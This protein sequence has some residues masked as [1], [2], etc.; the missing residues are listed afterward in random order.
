MH[1]QRC[2][3][4]WWWID[5]CICTASGFSLMNCWVIIWEWFFNGS[6]EFDW[7]LVGAW[8]CEKIYS[9]RFGAWDWNF[10]VM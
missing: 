3:G 4:G 1:K 8:Y 2:E 5:V 6:G 10:E 7:V 9:K